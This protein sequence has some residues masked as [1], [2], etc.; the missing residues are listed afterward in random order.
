MCSSK[1]CGLR[2]CTSASR[3]ELFGC[4]AGTLSTSEGCFSKAVW[5]IR[6]RPHMTWSKWLDCGQNTLTCDFF[7]TLS[8]LRT[9]HIVAQG[10]ARR[11]C[12]KHIH[13]HVITCLGVC[14][15]LC[16]VFFFCLSCLYCFSLTST[17]SLS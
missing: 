10:V 3:N 9:H 4:S 11:V 12:I 7:S 8:S 17:C 14:C 16:F 15:F 1:W 5:R 6:C 13:P 2:Q